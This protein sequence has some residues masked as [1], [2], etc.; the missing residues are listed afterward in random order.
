MGSC[1]GSDNESTMKCSK[2]ILSAKAS[3]K[4]GVITEGASLA[5]NAGKSYN[6][7]KS[8]E[9]SWEEHQE[10]MMKRSISAAGSAGLGAVGT[11]IGTLLFPGV[12][13]GIICGMAGSYIGSWVGRKVHKTMF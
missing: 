11:F 2:A 9:R 1:R 13:G 8:G 7:Y 12:M 10:I 6:K 5:C 4:A 3:L